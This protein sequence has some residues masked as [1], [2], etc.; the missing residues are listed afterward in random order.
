MNAPKAISHQMQQHLDKELHPG[1]SI[2]WS[3]QPSSSLMVFKSSIFFMLSILSSG[4]SFVSSKDSILLTFI[5]TVWGFPF[6]L[7]GV[8]FALL[9]AW[10][11]WEALRTVYAITD[12]RAIL[13]ISPWRRTIYSFVGEHLVEIQCFENKTGSGD[14]IFHREKCKGTRSRT[15]FQA[16]GFL[17][18]KN[19][20]EVEDS[21]R[22]L[23]ANKQAA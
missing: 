4:L 9:P 14:I 22:Q 17:G 7:G 8:F 2:I 19:V 6:F 18:I 21:L 5:F 1:E 15:Y 23:Y 10:T 3:Q 20:R 12:Q 13:I 16:V 11:Y